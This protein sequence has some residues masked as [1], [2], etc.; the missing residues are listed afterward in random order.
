MDITSDN[1]KMERGQVLESLDGIMEKF[2]K[3]TGKMESKLVMAH[4]NLPKEIIIKESGSII[5]SMAKVFL[6]IVL[7][8]TK[9]NSKIFS[10]MDSVRRFL[11]MVI[12]MK[13]PTNKVSL[14]AEVDISGIKEGFIKVNSFKE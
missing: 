3:E 7:V 13:G 8:P 1:L 10:K 6:S 14:M 5:D 2:S 11:Q 12:V 4:G 9:E